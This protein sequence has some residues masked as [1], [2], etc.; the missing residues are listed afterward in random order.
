MIVGKPLFTTKEIQTKVRELADRISAD[1]SGKDLLAVGILRGA[2][3]F[4]SDLVRA[5]KAPLTIDFIVASSYVKMD[6]LGEVKIHCDIREDISDKDVLLI[7][8]IIDSGITLNQIRERI[9][10]RRPSS[11]KICVFLDKKERR[12]VDVPVDYIGFE[13]PNEYVVGY[14]LDYDNKFRNLPYIS[15]FKKKA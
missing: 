6:T 12:M 13:I 1:Y 8:D 7:D 10:A 14:G 9:L 4:F 3:M 15:I 2:F 5:I 11:L